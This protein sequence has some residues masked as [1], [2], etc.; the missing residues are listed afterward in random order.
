MK[1]QASVLLMV[2]AV[3]A[4]AQ[5]GDRQIVFTIDDLPTASVLGDD[6]PR[7]K[8]TT[9]ALLGALIRQKVPAIGFV[10][11]RK[12]M[13]D[14]VPQPERVALLQ[15]WI[16]AGFELGNHTFGHIDLHRVELDAFKADVVKGEVSTRRLLERAGRP[17]TFFRHPFLHTGTSVEARRG[18]ETFLRERNYVIAP[19][20][21]D[22][23]DY[24]F[25][26]AYDRAIERGDA[27]DARRIE[28]TYLEYMDSVVRYYE[29]QAQV[30]VGR[31]IPHTLLLH[32]HALNGVTLDRLAERLR[33]RGYRFIQL[34]EA[35]RDPAYSEKDE[36]YGPAGISWLQ[37]CALT[38]GKR[39]IF[40][41]EPV[42]PEWIERAANAK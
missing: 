26:A 12:L 18:L 20:T 32:A 10:N 33:E 38:A 29:Q 35:L 4:P 14:G 1:V 5:P 22:N 31:A 24:V 6:L 40:A 8:R 23:Y 39:G 27:E 15:Q 36:Y 2:L 30:I 3:L 41:G 7:A 17:L 34:G 13:A 19:V 25:A 9:A 16:D 21:I 42:V 28:A 11:E 37:R